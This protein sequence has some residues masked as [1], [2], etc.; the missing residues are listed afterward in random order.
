MRAMTLMSRNRTSSLISLVEKRQ[1]K[2]PDNHVML[3]SDQLKN[4]KLCKF[5][6]ATSHSTNECRVFR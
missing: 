5:H 6:S 3:P 4:K 1:I 2:L